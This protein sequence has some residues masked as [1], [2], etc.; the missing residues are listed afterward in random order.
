MHAG[1]RRI[2]GMVIFFSIILILNINSAASNLKSP[3]R[4]FAEDCY[5][6][7]GN[8][9]CSDMSDSSSDSDSSDDSSAGDPGS[10]STDSGGGSDSDS[11][12]SSDSNP[13]QDFTNNEQDITDNSNTEN[14]DSTDSESDSDLTSNDNEIQTENG[15]NLKPLADAG[16][17]LEVDEGDKVV[18]DGSSSKD[19]DGSISTYSWNQIDGNPS[20]DLNDA[21]SSTASFTAPDVESVQQ[22]VFHLSV[23]DNAGSTDGDSVNVLVRNVDSGANQE[24]EQKPTQS[25]SDS[26]TSEEV[27]PD[28]QSTATD[29]NQSFPNEQEQINPG[30]LVLPKAD[31][32]QENENISNSPETSIPPS[33]SMENQTECND[34]QEPGVVDCMDSRYANASECNSS[35]PIAPCAENE[36]LCNPSELPLSPILPNPCAGNMTGAECN[37]PNPCAGNMTGAECNPPNPC[38]GNMTGA[39]CNPPN[40]CAGNMTGAE[41]NP[42]NPCAGNMTGAEC[43]P[44]NPCAGNMTGAECNPPN[45]CA[46]NMTGAECNPPNPCAGNMTG[47]ECNPP[48]PCAGNMTGAECKRPEENISPFA[49]AGED[50]VVDEDSVVTLDASDSYDADGNISSYSWIQNSG[51]LQS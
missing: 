28:D 8:Y 2:L 19:N 24:N 9:I 37:P 38:A 30:R 23:S 21:E 4:V 6:S 34:G 36:T 50:Q 13:N 47:A 5:D 40:P 48:N 25:E 44:P 51:T 17:D 32:V 3:Q 20:V 10:D 42:P 45:P 43:N 7:D 16:P 33:G 22:L 18:L 27:I 49:N 14:M 11:S 26:K 15:P 31:Q 1:D 41:C 12:D 46:G 29:N 39:E 35:P